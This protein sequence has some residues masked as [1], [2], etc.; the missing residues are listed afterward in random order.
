MPKF[1]FQT[2]GGGETAGIVKG[3]CE[4]RIPMLMQSTKAIDPAIQEK[5]G[6]LFSRAWR[7][8]QQRT[9]RSWEKKRARWLELLG[10][11]GAEVSSNQLRVALNNLVSFAQL[12]PADTTLMRAAIH[13]DYLT[14][15]RLA[16][17]SLKR[18]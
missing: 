1:F 15:Q 14:M 9:G 3:I 18:Y 4:D 6:Q 2:I 13:E 7:R 12:P 16:V 17:D 10:A 11:D 5:I 8:V